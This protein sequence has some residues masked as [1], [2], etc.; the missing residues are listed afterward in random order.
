MWIWVFCISILL[1]PH[2]EWRGP[3]EEALKLLCP[4]RKGIS[5]LLVSWCS[6]FQ[7]PKKRV[8]F[9]QRWVR[10]AQ[11][12]GR[13]THMWSDPVTGG[14]R[15]TLTEH[16]CPG[17]WEGAA[18]WPSSHLFKGF[19]RDLVRSV[20]SADVQS[21]SRIPGAVVGNSDSI[22]LLF[23]CYCPN[24]QGCRG[25]MRPQIVTVGLSHNAVAFPR[26]F[27]V[28]SKCFPS[29]LWLPKH[30]RGGYYRKPSMITELESFQIMAS[31]WLG[32]RWICGATCISSLLSEPGTT[33]DLFLPIS[34]F[35]YCFY[36]CTQGRVICQK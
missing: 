25:A 15:W 32:R 14:R 27:L 6:F 26:G 4:G 13:Y 16:Q 36:K 17:Q 9:A 19:W 18:A 20:P 34:V 5:S 35:C 7:R 28:F 1:V 8:R 22:L 3:M 21:W 2:R 12:Y 24:L 29:L 11:K 30:P 23:P 31:A 10:Y 33:N